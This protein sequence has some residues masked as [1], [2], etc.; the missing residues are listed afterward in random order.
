MLL[1]TDVVLTYKTGHETITPLQ[2][3]S[4][5]VSQGDYV[6][7][8]GASGSGKSSLL[9]VLSGLRPPTAGKVQFESTDLSGASART[10]ARLR[11]KHFGFV[12]QQHFLLPYLTVLENVMVGATAKGPASGRRA[13]ELLAALG[14]ESTVRQFPGQLSGGQRQRVAAAR[15]LVHRPAIL[16]ADEP[17]AS[18]DR[19]NATRLMDLVERER[20]SVTVV[21]VTHDM[22]IASRAKR[23]L[24]LRDGHLQTASVGEVAASVT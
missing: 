20:G 12:F 22:E 10:L 13:L 17:T 1:A 14:L 23:V 2:R 18:L 3:V 16:F 8:T 21:L 4:L 11:R 5:R 7:I 24:Q 15:A 19:E 6:A 9:Y